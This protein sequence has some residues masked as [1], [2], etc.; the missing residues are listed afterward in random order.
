M[1]KYTP[2]PK[3][4]KTLRLAKSKPYGPSGSA[5]WIL[6]KSYFGDYTAICD[7][8]T[9]YEGVVFFSPTRRTQIPV[10]GSVFP[11]SFFKEEIV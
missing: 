2:E 8:L 7:F 5:Q 3:L 10:G 6:A 11:V 4:L 1:Y 9:H